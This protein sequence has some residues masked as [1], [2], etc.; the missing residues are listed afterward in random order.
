[1]R[2][3]R[4]AVL[5]EQQTGCCCGKIVSDR[6][7][8]ANARAR[9]IRHCEPCGAQYTPAHPS[10]KQLR[11]GHVQVPGESPDAKAAPKSDLRNSL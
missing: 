4:R 8:S 7:R 3:L 10:A 2:D 1:M 6:T 9:K 5:D 11:A